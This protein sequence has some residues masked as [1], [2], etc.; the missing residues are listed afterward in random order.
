[1][2]EEKQIDLEIG[3][4]NGLNGLGGPDKVTQVLTNLIGNAVK[5]TP[6]LVVS[7]AGDKGRGCKFPPT[8][9]GP[10]IPPEEAGKIFDEFY[11]MSQPGRDKSKEW[12]W[13][14]DLQSSWRCM[15]ENPS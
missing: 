15:G 10:G 3:L 14:G 5:F 4:T 6:N 8:D 9:T 11:Q 12:A 1:M 7:M 13:S 2:A